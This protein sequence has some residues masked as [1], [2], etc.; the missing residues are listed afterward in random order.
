MLL[1]LITDSSFILQKNA[2]IFQTTLNNRSCI[3][4]SEYSIEFQSCKWTGQ[5]ILRE[6]PSVNYLFSPFSQGL[7]HTHCHPPA[8]AFPLSQ[9]SLLSVS[10]WIWALTEL[11]RNRGYL[12][13]SVVKNPPAMQE[14]WVWSLGPED[15]G[16]GRIPWRR[17]WLPT[18][19]FLPGKCHGQRSLVGYSPWGWKESD[20]DMTEQLNSRVWV[21]GLVLPLTS[22]ASLRHFSSLRKS[23]PRLVI[24][25][26]CWKK[27]FDSKRNFCYLWNTDTVLL[28]K[29]I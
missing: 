14:T 8:T 24:I 20:A 2:S 29:Q 3:R 10:T 27:S 23:I 18:L 26:N 11:L 1:I 19:V 15:P 9:T 25:Q 21:T 16:V 22:S 4:Q 12:G 28:R 7:H 13:G 5:N 6:E 17:I